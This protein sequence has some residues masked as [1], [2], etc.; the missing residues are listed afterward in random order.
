MSAYPPLNGQ[1]EYDQSSLENSSV[2]RSK[3]LPYTRCPKL[4]QPSVF[5][6]TCNFAGIKTSDCSAIVMFKL[7]SFK[8]L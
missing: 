7:I 5:S 4:R 8:S 6:R 3:E 1:F 2:F